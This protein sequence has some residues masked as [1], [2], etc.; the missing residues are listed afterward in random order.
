MD[1]EIQLISDGDGLAVIGEPTAVEKFL[2]SAGHWAASKELDLGR[3]KPLLSIGSD[4]AEAASEIAANSG[5]WIKLT[6]ESARLV[7]EHGLMESKMPGESHL[8]IGIPGSVKSWLQAETGPA[9][10]LTN[11]AALSG[12]AGIMAQAAKQQTMAEIA[13]YLVRI[14]EKVD[15]VLLKVDGTVLKDMLGA[16][17]QIRRALTMREQERRVTVDSWSEVQNASGKLSDVQGYAL[18]QLEE[19]AEKLENKTRIGG[20]A[21]TTEVEKPNVHKWLAVLAEVLPTTGGLRRAGA[22]SGARRVSAG[23]GRASSRPGS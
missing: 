9:S 17:L 20:L 13:D 22:R 3:L 19:I 2:R 8:M 6:E 15:D 12:V 4:V 23:L 21:Q 18:I 7:K 11:P 14:D 16:R 10:L 1:N 5:R